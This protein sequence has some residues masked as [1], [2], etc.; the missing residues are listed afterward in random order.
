MKK[1]TLIWSLL[2]TLTFF[3]FILGYFK[4][5][6]N[7]FVFLLLITTFLKIQLIIDYFMNLREI[8]LKYR[9]LPTL[10]IVVVL[11][12]IAIAYYLPII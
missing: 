2:I 8:Q 5:I 7:F 6:N 4:V 9:I 11:V 10:W 1:T 12:L 3:A